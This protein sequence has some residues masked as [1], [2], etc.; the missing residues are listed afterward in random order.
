MATTTKQSYQMIKTLLGTKDSPQYVTPLI[1]GLPGIG[2]SYN[3][4]KYAKEFG[5]KYFIDLRLS[6][7]D[8]TDFKMPVRGES[9][10]HWI[11]SDFIPTE[12]NP[13]YDGPGVL[14]LDEINRAS[15]KVMQSIFQI[16]YD[17]MIGTKK[18]RDDWKIIAAGNFGFKDRT[19]VNELDSALKNRFAII[20]IDKVS[21]DDYIEE[22]KSLNKY[23]K[24]FLETNP[25]KLYMDEGDYLV[26]PR[27]WTTLSNY[28]NS[29]QGSD[30]QSYASIISRTII[31]NAAGAFVSFLS[32]FKKIKPSDIFDGT[33]KTFIKDYERAD[34]HQ[35]N[36]EIV[37]YVQDKKFTK[38][39]LSNFD[40]YFNHHL[41]EDNR[42]WILQKLVS[43]E[44][45]KNFVRQYIEAFPKYNVNGSEFFK[46]LS[47]VI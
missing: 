34:I 6:Q 40:K 22:E 4:K 33:Y 24:I 46:L 25:S 9:F 16:V 7:H 45:G 41:L 27:S 18:I 10:V 14:F 38:K 17:R 13:K 31:H 37:D 3:V 32:D 20:E 42:I 43:T 11:T 29:Y 12:D 15:E 23:V 30:I 44:K 39:E 28:L 26:T 47:K 2:K 19:F 36:A 8:E 1:L 35:L 5:F 21:V